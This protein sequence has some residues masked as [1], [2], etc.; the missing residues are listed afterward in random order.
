MSR[1]LA[2]T[3]VADH[4]NAPV[5]APGYLPVMFTMEDLDDTLTGLR[6]HGAELIDQVV[7]YQERIVCATS[8][9]PKEFSSALARNSAESR[10]RSIV[11]AVEGA[12][13]QPAT[14]PPS[15]D[16]LP[17]NSSRES[18]VRWPLHTESPKSSGGG[19]RPRRPPLHRRGRRT[20]RA[21]GPRGLRAASPMLKAAFPDVTPGLQQQLIDGD[22]VVSHSIVRG[23]VRESSPESRRSG[24]SRSTGTSSPPGLPAAGMF[25][26]RRERMFDRAAPDRR[27]S[28]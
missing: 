24:S 6:E 16:V 5:N 1:F 9:V 17:S 28:D 12:R 15:E 10:A 19:P 23:R 2:P 22:R 26:I 18:S 4:R 3:I 8:G 11:C 21:P 25:S 20:R 14:S 27:D 13:T 7:K